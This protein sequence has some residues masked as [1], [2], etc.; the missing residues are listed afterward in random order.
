MCGIIAMAFVF[1][2][3]LDQIFGS[4]TETESSVEFDPDRAYEITFGVYGDLEHAYAEVFASGHFTSLYPNIT[5]T[6]QSDDYAGHHD[7]L[8]TQLDAGERTNDIEALEIAYVTRFV[9]Q[10]DYLTDLNQSPYNADSVTGDL[11]EF[12][13]AQ[14]QT[15]NNQQVAIPVDIAPAVLFYREDLALEHGADFKNLDSWDAYITESIKVTGDGRYAVPNAL[16]FA[17]LTFGGRGGWISPEGNPLEP[18]EKFIEALELVR[19]VRQAGID[20]DLAVWESPWI[21][22]FSDGS[23]VTM[24][25]GAWWG[26][27]LR[28][29]VAPNVQD[30][31]VTRLPGQT[32]ASLGGSF[33]S[34]PVTV[35]AENRGAAW[36]VIKYLTTT[37]EAQLSIFAEI[38]A[39]PVL[40]TTYFDPIMDEE[41]TYFGD[42]QVRRLFA[43]VAL[44]MPVHRLSVNDYTVEG[45]W[46]M[47]AGEVL[48][49]ELTPEQAYNK[50]L[51]MIEEELY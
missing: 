32:M 41:I 12:A 50:A 40:T 8:T 30:W 24:P 48:E 49:G 33:L 42:E 26:G 46:Q 31:R 20:A 27:P 36:E 11:A 7:R 34:I 35:P 5:I 39:F 13:V 28:T 44:N 6:L 25:N 1:T 17:M 38:D 19:D 4:T 37:S 2:G 21:E 18:K 22:S 47:L 15:R 3:C 43:D 9:G 51:E 45:I 14:V 10:G 23:V 16:D 29:W